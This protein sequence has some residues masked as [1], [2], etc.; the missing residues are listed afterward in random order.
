MNTKI[1][2]NLSELKEFIDVQAVEDAQM[3]LA[4]RRHQAEVVSD[5]IKQEPLEPKVRKDLLAQYSAKVAILTG[6]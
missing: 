3:T 2:N 5:V 6:S 4:E 1:Q